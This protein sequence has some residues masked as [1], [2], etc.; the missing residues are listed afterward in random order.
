MAYFKAPTKMSDGTE[1]ICQSTAPTEKLTDYQFP[2]N[3]LTDIALT[4]ELA[5]SSERSVN[6]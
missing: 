1:E 6:F 2:I 4:M 5:N 3:L